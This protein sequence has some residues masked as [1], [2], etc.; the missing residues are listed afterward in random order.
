MES[1]YDF[2]YNKNKC[3]ELHYNYRQACS[4]GKDVYC[5]DYN[6]AKVG[7][8]EVEGIYEHSAMGEGDRWFFDIVYSTGKTERIFNPCKAI[9]QN[10]K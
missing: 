2:L 1:T 9:Y 5:E 4:D 6:V 8:K 7:E 10:A 3:I